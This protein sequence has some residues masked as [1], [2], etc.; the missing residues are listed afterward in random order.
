MMMKLFNF[1]VAYSAIVFCGL[2]IIAGCSSSRP[3]DLPKLADVTITITQEGKPLSGAM[4]TLVDVAQS[5]AT[6]YSAG[7]VTDGNGVCQLY[8]HGQYKGSPHGKFKVRVSRTETIPRRTR[9]PKS[10]EENEEMM[11]S[12]QENPPKTYQFVEKIY[13]DAK[14][15]PLEIEINGSTTKNFDVGKAV[16]EQIDKR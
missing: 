9:K 8:T 12:F 15:T 2:L 4:V 5:A 6:T 7:G 3:S 1:N 14:T 16:K 13:T 10:A 11:K